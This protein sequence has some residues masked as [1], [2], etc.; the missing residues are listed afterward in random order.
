M[1]NNIAGVKAFLRK[2][3]GIYEE[4]I[5]FD[6]SSW[7]EFELREACIDFILEFEPVAGAFI[8]GELPYGF[9]EDYHM[10][11]IMFCK[12]FGI[13]SVCNDF[14]R[15]QE[16]PLGHW[17]YNESPIGKPVLSKQRLK[18]FSESTEKC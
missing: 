12:H 8:C 7:Q 18:R 4:G 9:H 15:K 16:N 10:I 3:I 11:N 5:F 2:A 6:N 14:L 13:W 17:F 1:E